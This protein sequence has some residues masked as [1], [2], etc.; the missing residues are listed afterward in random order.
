MLHLQGFLQEP[1]HHQVSPARVACRLCS[2]PSDPPSLL[3]LPTTRCRH[4]FCEACALQHYRKSKRCYVCNTQTNG[5]FNPAKGQ[6]VVPP[7]KSLSEPHSY[8]TTTTTSPPPCFP[9]ISE[10]IAKM[11]KRQ[12]LADQP[13]SEGDDDDD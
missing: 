4:Y 12:A 5:V 11:E 2:A 7:Q 3:P 10:L 6:R 1:H 9:S 13:P 8:T